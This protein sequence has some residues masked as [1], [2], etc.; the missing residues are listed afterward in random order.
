[1]AAAIADLTALRDEL[2]RLEDKLADDPAVLA[3]HPE[4]QLLDAAGQRLARIITALR[5]VAG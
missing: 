1:M 4:V 3:S 5:G 2:G